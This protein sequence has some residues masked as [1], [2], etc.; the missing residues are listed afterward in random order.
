MADL[1]YVV[2]GAAL[3][4]PEVD[5]ATNVMYVGGRKRNACSVCGKVYSSFRGESFFGIEFPRGTLA[6]GPESLGIDDVV[7][8]ES[9]M[10]LLSFVRLYHLIILHLWK[11]MPHHLPNLS[12][13]IYPLHASFQYQ[14]TNSSSS[15][16]RAC[17][18]Q[19]KVTARS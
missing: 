16:M 14:L 19:L 6:R 2:W 1:L 3:E 17:R 5:I 18:I 13:I 9:P 7:C 12:S 15:S 10:Y 11:S 4:T 8:P